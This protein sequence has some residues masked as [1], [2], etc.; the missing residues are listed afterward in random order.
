MRVLLGGEARR[1]GVGCHRVVV[2]AIGSCGHWVERERGRQRDGERGIA[3]GD[4]EKARDV[5]AGRR[6]DRGP[7]EGG[8]RAGP[9][10]G[11]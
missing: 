3:T 5:A 11:I 9:K 2:K 7:R 6:G 4:W 8:R 10:G 1:V